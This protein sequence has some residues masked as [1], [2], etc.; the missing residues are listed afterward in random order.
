MRRTATIVISLLLPLAAYAQVVVPQPRSNT[1]HPALIPQAHTGVAHDTLDTSNPHIKLILCTDGT[2]H[3]AQD[4]EM[5]KDSTVFKEDWKENVLNPYGY[6]DVDSLP[7]RVTLSLTDSVR[8]Y[9]CPNR[10]RPSSP[11]GMRGRHKHTGID[12]PYPTGTPA[13]AAFDGKVRVSMYSGGY[14]NLVVIRHQN[15]METYY[16]HLSERKVE[17]GD[18]VHAG[19]VV[20]LGG[21]TGRSTGPHLHF[22]TRYHG[23]AFDPKWLI[24]FE[25]GELRY[26]VFVLKRKHL[27]IFAKY[28]PESAD[29]EEE[30]NLEQERIEK[31]EKEEK[32]RKAAA[33][34]K[35]VQYHIVKQGDTLGAIAL[36]YH[37]TV[38]ALCRLNNIKATTVLRI[39]MKLRVR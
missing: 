32:A 38:A 27:S 26:P 30:V 36:K 3:Y 11:F 12:L 9:R 22:E 8:A 39:N 33:A 18:W 19:D 28:Y 13:Y 34:Q 20:G 21:S 31:A 16:A 17:A 25:T 29:E 24:D 5:L 15:G 1:E 7:E 4:L 37:T 23:L 6:I 35:A 10:T 2:W 14:G